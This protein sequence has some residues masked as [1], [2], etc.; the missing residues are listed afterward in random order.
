MKVASALEGFKGLPAILT[1][2]EAVHVYTNLLKIKS[3]QYLLTFFFNL[4]F[5]TFSQY[6]SQY[7]TLF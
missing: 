1:V 5:K 7:N 6:F 3:G 4:N 2:A